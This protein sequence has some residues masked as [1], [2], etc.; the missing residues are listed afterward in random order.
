[1]AQ[2]VLPSS[3]K[4]LLTTM[5]RHL[6]EE[7]MF[8]V[9]T[10][11]QLYQ[12]RL[13]STPGVSTYINTGMDGAL[14][15]AIML[16]ERVVRPDQLIR[17]V[18]W[19]TLDLY[20]ESPAGTWLKR[21]RV[22]G[23]Y[24]GTQTDYWMTDS[25]P[26]V[27]SPFIWYVGTN[28]VDPVQKWST[29]T[30]GGGQAIDLLGSPDPGGTHFSKAIAMYQAC[31]FHLNRVENLVS[32]PTKLKWSDAN[33]IETYTGGLS[34]ELQLFQGGFDAG[35]ALASLGPYLVAYRRESIHIISFTGSP[36]FFSQRQVVRGIGLLA[37]RAVL[38]LDTKHL[39]LG[40]DN[41]YMFNGVDIQPIANDIRD[42]L[43]QDM[44]PAEVTRCFWLHD[45]QRNMATLMVP[46]IDD[47]QCTRGW[48]YNLTSGT[49]SG[50]TKDFVMTGGGR[51]VRSTT[52]TWADMTMPWSVAGGSW[53]SASAAIGAPLV[54][55]GNESMLVFFIDIRTSRLN[56][57][58]VT[59]RFESRAVHPG[60]QMDP[61]AL[62]TICVELYPLTG[63]GGGSI[64]WFVGTSD[65]PEGPFTFYGP[66]RRGVRGLVKTQTLRGK[67]FI[68]AAQA[69]TYFE[70]HGLVA[71]H[72]PSWVAS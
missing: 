47:T 64:D 20:V 5:P 23:P 9:S 50:P 56:G 3:A 24:T 49:W 6:L 45:K 48:H 58:P 35:V 10:N 63:D 65:N 68:F 39:F 54:M 32:R 41:V 30:G 57:A 67:W 51:G 34:G 43:F 40:L 38:N 7:G 60:A 69:D 12:G 18:V 22:S 46:G 28:G 19:T 70:L 66:Y 61:P 55:F 71:N 62:E 13:I 37:P 14:G 11:L 1:M 42:D 27:A 8:Y 26:N 59:G 44:N 33:L 2:I 29:G 17:L 16:I 15:S 4:G 31:L 53:A 36:F 72:Q 52:L 21:T 25:C